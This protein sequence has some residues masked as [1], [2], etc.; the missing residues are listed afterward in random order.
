MI[1]VPVFY[2]CETDKVRIPLKSLKEKYYVFKLKPELSVALIDSR[3]FVG[4]VFK[5]KQTFEI[6]ETVMDSIMTPL[7]HRPE[8]DEEQRFLTEY[9]DR[10]VVFSADQMNV[11]ELLKLNC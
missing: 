7:L 9:K 6:L 2:E 10:Q 1:F 11:D 3:R 5:D 8:M 4:E